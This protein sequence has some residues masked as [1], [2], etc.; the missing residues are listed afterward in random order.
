MELPRPDSFQE[1]D[2]GEDGW[3]DEEEPDETQV[4]LRSKF[5]E[6][7]LWEDVLLPSAADRTGLASAKV[8]RPLPDSITEWG[9]LAVSASPTTGFCAAEP[10]NVRAW[11]PFFVDLKLP[12]SVAR[13]EQVELKAVV[14][15]Y[16]DD[17][18][19]VRV[20]LMKTEH[21]CSVAF[22]GKHVQDVSVP[23]GSSVVIPYTVAPLA[24]GQLPLEVMAVT[25]DMMGTDRIQKTLRVVL[26]GVQKTQVQSVMLNPSAEGG[27][28]T[29]QVRRVELESVVPN[30]VPD[31]FI[32]VRGNVLADSI[33]NSI[34]DDSLA[35]LI[36]MPGGCVEQNLASMTLPLIATLYLDRTDGWPKVGIHRKDEAL[37]YIQKGYTNQLAYRRSDGSYPPYQK[38]GA[39]TWITAYVVKVFSMAH[40]IMGIEEQQV[41]DPLLYLLKNMHRPALGIFVEENPVYT[42]TMTGG[43]RGDDPQTT[44]T[45]FVLIALAEAKQTGISCSNRDINVENVIHKTANHLRRALEVPRR[46]YT[47]AIAA[48]ALALLKDNIDFNPTQV[49]LRAAAP[50]RSHWPDSENRLFTLEA[51]GYAL[52]AL[53]KMGAMTEA[54]APFK[55]LNSRRRQGGGFG[56]TQPTMVVLQALSEYM[57]SQPPP[58]NMNLNVEVQMGAR[59]IPYNFNPDTAY[60]ARSSRLP[61]NVDLVVK[62]EGN[63]Q[64]IL[65]VVTYYNQ[66]HEVEEKTACKDFELQVTIEESTEKPPPDVL[67]SYTMTIRVRALGPKDVRMVVLDVSLPT[68]F[69]PENSDLE[70]LSNSIDKYITN[71]QIVD[72]LSERGSLIMHMFKV[73]HKEPEILIFRLQQNF[74]VGHIQPSPVTVYEYYNPDHRCSRTYSPRENTEEL[75]QICRDNVCRC[76]QGD[77]CVHKTDAQNFT[78]K[79]RETFA[80]T[81]LHHVFKVKVLGVT[82][83]YYDKYDMEITQL[84]KLGDEAGVTVGQRRTFMSHGACRDSLRLIQ[85]QEYLIIGPKDDQWNVDRDTNS[86]VYMLG[87][88]TWV[89]RWPSSEECSSDPS[90]KNKCDT[91]STMADDLSTNG[92]QL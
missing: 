53:V 11:K 88:N 7:W 32:N 30:S 56:S 76:T 20:T 48:Y 67:K 36:R 19:N 51:T 71:F 64:G 15:N 35:A 58:E 2:Y 83:S 38:Q 69:T 87:K 65:E 82:E 47:V 45:A 80:C 54:E 52:L 29:V 63:G 46:P 37:K 31:T 41:C 17:T 40:S 3:D 57:V 81:T 25:Q 68:G 6:S 55:W 49:L 72:N 24:V 60:A 70:M 26:E 39:S 73:S 85:G 18:V 84:I 50:D 34:N 21:I 42:T 28:Q 66:L 61:D 86:F 75:K 62:A 14:Y 33:D 12:Y 8:E 1:E 92:C 77:C 43:L 9:V 91:L 22:R 23:A 90:L 27:T 10:Y 4:D 16:G 44:L 59:T 13:Y 5:Y 78:N 79:D 89:E 74:K